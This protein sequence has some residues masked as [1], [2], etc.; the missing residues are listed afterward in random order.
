M[1][2]EISFDPL[3]RFAEIERLVAKVYFR[4]SHLFFHQ[5]DLRDFWWQ[6][7]MDEEQHSVN[8]LACKEIINNLPDEALAP[9]VSQEKADQLKEKIN[10]YLS[11]GTPSITREEAFK[12]ALELESS[13]L[14]VI[15]SEILKLGGPKIAKTMENL[16]IPVRDHRLRLKSVIDRFTK[17]PELCAAAKQL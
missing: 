12:V 8:L 16:G 7:A 14:N 5:A 13:E 1:G 4:F 6:M 9:S 15:Y 17:D 10:T 2:S 11:K 3:E